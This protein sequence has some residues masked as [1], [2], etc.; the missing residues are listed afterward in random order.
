MNA[1][2]A[3]TK[4][5]L[6]SLF[7]VDFVRIP[8]LISIVFGVLSSSTIMTYIPQQALENLK[9]YQYK[10]VDRYDMQQLSE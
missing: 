1:F 9:K 4:S 5:L 8:A 7:F 2:Y 10:G 6:D 3:F